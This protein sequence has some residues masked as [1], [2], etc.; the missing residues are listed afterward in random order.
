MLEPRYHYSQLY[1]KSTA[2]DCCNSAIT[3]NEINKDILAKL[4]ELDIRANDLMDKCLGSTSKY[5]DEVDEL[6]DHY[7]QVYVKK[8]LSSK[9]V[10]NY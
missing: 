8:V 2:Y 5:D 7:N 10:L 4:T 1:I 3:N 6:R 9:I